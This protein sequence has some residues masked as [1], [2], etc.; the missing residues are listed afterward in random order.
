[1]IFG[2]DA[3][4]GI[5]SDY[6]NKDGLAFVIHN[7]GANLDREEDALSHDTVT[8][9]YRFDASLIEPS[10]LRAWSN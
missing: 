1:M 9:H 5:I 3:H 10:V 8:G 6:R 2:S 7:G 4:I